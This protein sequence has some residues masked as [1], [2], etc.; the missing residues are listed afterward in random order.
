[1]LIQI[2][3]SFLFWCQ[4]STLFSALFSKLSSLE[5]LLSHCLAHSL[6]KVSLL[7]IRPYFLYWF[8]CNLFFTHWKLFC[9]LSIFESAGLFVYHLTCLNAIACIELSHWSTSINILVIHNFKLPSIPDLQSR[10]FS[11]RDNNIQP[12]IPGVFRCSMAVF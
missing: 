7:L 1:M 4:F 11:W 10:G 3:D 12:R 8:I 9:W 5:W 6:I 2:T